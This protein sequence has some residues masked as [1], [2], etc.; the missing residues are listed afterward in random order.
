[1]NYFFIEADSIYETMPVINNWYGKID[2]RFIKLGQSYKLPDRELLFIQGNPNTQFIDVLSYPFFMVS[3]LVKEVIQKY[4][5]KTIFKEIVLL[6][7]EN[8][9][10]QIYYYPILQEYDCL[11]DKSE[12]NLDRSHIRRAIFDCDKIPDC[13]IFRLSNVKKSYVAIRLDLVE[14][15]LRRG[16]RG[17]K[18]LPVEIASHSREE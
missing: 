10:T 17:I 5:P 3:S 7:S 8:T 15:L 1:M 16:S 2:E 11:S 13:S 4:E 6:D 14:S 12:I 18:L 9:L